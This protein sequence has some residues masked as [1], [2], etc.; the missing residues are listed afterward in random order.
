MIEA[1]RAKDGLVRRVTVQTASGL[2]E[3]SATKVAVLDVGAKEVSL[4]NSS[5]APRGNVATLR[6]ATHLAS[7]Q[8]LLSI[9]GKTSILSKCL[10]SK[11]CALELLRRGSD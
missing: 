5:D 7:T 9:Q 8:T 10:V 2:L 4:L 3:R 6:D 1:V 11:I